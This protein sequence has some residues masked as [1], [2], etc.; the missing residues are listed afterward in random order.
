MAVY[1]CT[2]PDGRPGYLWAVQGQAVATEC[3]VYTPGDE[4]GRAAAL[5]LAI[6]DE[7]AAKGPAAEETT[8]PL[9]R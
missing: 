4:K 1:S 2:G 8:A 3:H 5:R 9:V 6:R 7:V